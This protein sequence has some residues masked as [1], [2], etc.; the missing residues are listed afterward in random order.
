[1]SVASN[2]QE[3]LKLVQELK[4]EAG[5]FKGCITKNEECKEDDRLVITK[6][7]CFKKSEEQDAEEYYGQKV[8]ML[9]TEIREKRQKAS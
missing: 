3:C 7:N 1:M 8:N 5:R 4:L 9:M 6:R 2:Y